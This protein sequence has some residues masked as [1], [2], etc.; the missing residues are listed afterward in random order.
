MAIGKHLQDTAGQLTYE[1]TV[2]LTPRTK[3]V[4]AQTRPNLSVERGVG[5]T[6]L[7][8]SVKQ[9]AVIIFV[10]R[11]DNTSKSVGLEK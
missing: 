9:L 6:N 10:E 2:L 3:S 7:L 5:L 11:R 8:L 1:L 4:Q